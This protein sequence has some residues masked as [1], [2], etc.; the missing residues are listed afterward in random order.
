MALKPGTK[1]DLVSSMAAAMESAFEAE[2]VK[3]KDG[4]PPA[5]SRQDLRLM[6]IAIAQGVVKHLQDKAI[7]FRIESGFVKSSI[8]SG[9]VKILTDM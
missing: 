8:G 5:A 4:P 1:D 9:T 6:F 3:F 7:E 2:W